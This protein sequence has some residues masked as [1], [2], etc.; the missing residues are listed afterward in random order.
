[1]PRRW[2]EMVAGTLRTLG[3]R[4]QA[5]RM[6]REYVTDF[7]LP[8]ALSSR[9][10]ADGA[11]AAEGTGQY[12]GARELAAW[13]QRVTKAWPGVRVDHVEAEDGAQVPGTALSVRASIALGEL[14]ADDVCVEVVYGTT[15]ESD[16][17]TDPERGELTLESPPGGDGV[18]R[19][20]GQA[21]L[22]RPGPFGYTVRVLPRHQFLAGPAEL[23]LITLPVGP[24]GMD[25]GDLR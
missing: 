2:L 11:A 17:I 5:T 3:P 12:S 24:S 15:G 20:C 10:L 21:K 4:A 23:G 8:A 14:S 6:V 22:G 18:A 13:K 19:Y 7:Y 16:E 25:D 1:M 9:A